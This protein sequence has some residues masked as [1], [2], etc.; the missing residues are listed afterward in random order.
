MLQR[1]KMCGHQNFWLSRSGCCWN[2]CD[3]HRDKG[4]MS[5]RLALTRP[6]SNWARSS[7]VSAS[8]SFR[9]SFVVLS[10]SWTPQYS[11]QVPCA[12]ERF[13]RILIPFWRK[14]YQY[15]PSPKTLGHQQVALWTRI[16]DIPSLRQLLEVRK[17]SFCLLLKRL[18][19]RSSNPIS[20]ATWRELRRTLINR[21]Y[22]VFYLEIWRHLNLPSELGY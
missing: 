10:P 15:A 19:R 6:L 1:N 3:C 4:L 9:I 16:E 5:Q 22:W 18:D 8:S 2:A 17:P 21:R 13:F 11:H 14:A 20:F 12:H 7:W